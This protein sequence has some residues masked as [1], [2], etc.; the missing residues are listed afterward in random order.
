MG[1]NRS[2]RYLIAFVLAISTLTATPAHA[3]IVSFNCPTGGG[4]YQVNNGTLTGS[5]G[6]CSGDLT[7]DGS[8]TTID[9][10]SLGGTSLNTLTIPSSVTD[11][12]GAPF[13]NGGNTLT[14]ISVDV[15]NPNYSSLSG[16]LF[17][18]TQ[19]ELIAYPASKPGTT[20]VIPSSVT[21][22][23]YYAFASNKNLTSMNLPNTLT[24]LGGQTFISSVALSTVN[25]GTGLTNLGEQSFAWIP[26]LTSINVDASNTSFA[27]IGGVLYD[28]NISKLWA[29]PANKAGTSYTAPSTVTSTA[30]TVFASA[31]NLETVDLT[32]V[33][34]LSGQEF[35]DSTVVKEVIFGDSL[36]ILV[37][38]VF[39]SASGLVK[40][41]LGACLTTIQDGAFFGNN[42]LNSVI[43]AGKNPT[44][45]NYGFPN[46]VVPV[47]SLL[48]CSSSAPAFTLSPSTISATTGVSITGYTVSSTGGTIASYSIS[49]S[50]S[51]TPGLSFSTSTGLISG[52]P[53]TAAASRTYS[54]TAT[55]ATNSA[56]RDF[57]ITV[58]APSP[59]YVAPV[60]V[61]YLKT[62]TTPKINFKDGKFI[63]T[64]GTYNA[65][66]TLDGVVQ[67][68]TTTF[69]TPSTFTYNLLINGVVQTSLSVTSSTASATWNLPTSTSGSLMSC[70]VTVSANGVTNTDKSTDNTSAI[71]SA[72]STQATSV[73]TANT[74]YSVS[75]SANSKAYQK[76]LVDNRALWRKQVEAIRT[77][78]YETIARITANDGTKKMIADK[79]TALKVYIAAQK[80]SAA[81]YKAS[82]LAALSAREAA[83]KAALDAKN[84][85]IAKANAT[86]G[87]YIESI[88]YGVLIP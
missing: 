23:R 10:Y 25:I 45:L 11:I 88:G 81:D 4:T 49:P 41:T 2:G 74:D 65:G 20:Y 21:S 56:T 73:A 36:T 9:T 8:V 67:G 52:V 57:A 33:A 42:S 54:V 38:Q 26:T 7:L 27:S 6:T 1:K 5:T 87:T 39:Q 70:S 63:C 28:K 60:P 22:T 79:S 32:P 29:Y 75:Q 84:A 76:A 77:N 13:S 62:L 58:S 51:N 15:S 69:F 72:L 83:N 80:K 40:L 71:S 18:K 47:A 31:R 68:S 46:S 86:Y 43:Y 59:P 34:T 12:S 17:N 48:G 82:Q 55:N 64:P 30:Y 85:A 19:T 61:P 3:S 16:V 44:I 14:A 35:M 50:I 37:S 66:Y 78:Y 53:T 24:T